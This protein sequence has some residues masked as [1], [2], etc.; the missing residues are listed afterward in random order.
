MKNL[1]TYFIIIATI[2]SISAKSQ[3]QV[4]TTGNV[5]IGDSAQVLKVNGYVQGNVNGALHINTGNGNLWLGAQN[6]YYCHI[7]SDLPFAFNQPIISLNGT[8]GS[9][10]N[11]NL[12]LQ[13]GMTE[14]YG[15]YAMTMYT[16]K[17]PGI[18]YSLKTSGLPRTGP[19]MVLFQAIY[20]IWD[21][22]GIPISE[23]ILSR[24]RIQHL[25]LI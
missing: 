6:Y 21:L 3:I 1:R 23:L 22:I 8:I 13:T 10:N 14:L 7:N 16:Y 2:T 18:Q 9:Y 5:T 4:D 15:N 12:T 11:T 17:M 19:S 24:H 25:K 20:L